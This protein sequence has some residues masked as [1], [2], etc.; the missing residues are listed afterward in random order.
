[1]SDFDKNYS[2][3]EYLIKFDEGCFRGS[4]KLYEYM[5]ENNICPIRWYLFL[6]W[7]DR[8]NGCE[9]YWLTLYGNIIERDNLYSEYKHHEKI[10]LYILDMD[11][12]AF[13]D[14][15]LEMYYYSKLKYLLK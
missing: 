7:H 15:E 5:F 4:Q 9:T 13:I 6:R 1:M 3:F 14:K 2:L 12:K 11:D 8:C 10:F